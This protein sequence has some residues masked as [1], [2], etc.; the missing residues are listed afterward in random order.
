MSERTQVVQPPKYVAQPPP[1]IIPPDEDQTYDQIALRSYSL[2]QKIQG[3]LKYLW[4]RLRGGP[5]LV[6]ME[7]THFCNARC[8][9]C[10]FWKTER[11]GK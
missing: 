8:D 10:D 7:V 1:V 2:I 5:M 6:N 3:G 11:S 9:F 4:V